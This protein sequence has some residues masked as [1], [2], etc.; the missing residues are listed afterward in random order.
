MDLEFLEKN[1][2]GFWMV[3][4]WMDTDGKILIC[5]EYKTNFAL[6]VA[7]FLLPLPPDLMTTLLNKRPLHCTISQDDKN[8]MIVILEMPSWFK[9]RQRICHLLPVVSRVVV[10]MDNDN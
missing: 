6:S 7:I 9:G 1:L 8:G 2:D 5:F 3:K 10:S 4:F